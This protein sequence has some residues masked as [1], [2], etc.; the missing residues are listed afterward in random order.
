MIFLTNYT[1]RK[2][3][4]THGFTL[5]ELLVVIAII[6]VLSSIVLSSLAGTRI[7][8]NYAKVQAE[9]NQFIKGSII[10]QGESGK[11]LQGITGSSCT[12]CNCRSR[13]IRNIPTND[14]CYVNWLAA[15]TTIQTATNGT[16]RGLTN[17]VRDPWGS[18]YGLDEN[19]REN[20]PSDCRYDTIRSAG[21][22]GFLY[23]FDDLAYIVPFYTEPCS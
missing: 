20:G 11:K 8:A 18:P 12:D 21:P 13:D 23:D 6:G 15:L 7:K 22:N 19:E 3:S 9:I 14:I 1:K 4:H 16:I 10:A 5:I 17:F 2:I